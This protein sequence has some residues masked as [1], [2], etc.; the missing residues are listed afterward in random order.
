MGESHDIGEIR[1]HTRS[2]IANHYACQKIIKSWIQQPEYPSSQVIP[3]LHQELM[4][5]N[6]DYSR[7]GLIPLPPGAYRLTD[8]TTSNDGKPDN[9][10]VA[11]TD[12]QPVMQTYNNEL[13]TRLRRELTNPAE[14]LEQTINDAAWAY[15][16]FERIHPFL[17][18][19]GRIGRMIMKR[20]FKGRGYKDIIF[21]Q[22][23]IYSRGRN[24]H[25]DTLDAV[26]NSG[27]LAHLEI[28]LLEQLKFRYANESTTTN[29]QQ[30]DELINK[31]SL[32]ISSQ[33]AR[34]DLT[35]IWD[36]LKG[37]NLYGVESSELPT[38]A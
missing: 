38:A 36:G 22:S 20:I 14:K 15:Y 16:A 28:Y 17:D 33:K 23:E 12:V 8:V 18:G 27:N 37:L 2:E 5:D 11:G 31:K 4:K 25:M 32:E 19:S 1:H 35:E 29:V 21:Q 26:D 10:Y 6:D 7:K 9:F 34:K 3:S 24:E 13:D 30:I